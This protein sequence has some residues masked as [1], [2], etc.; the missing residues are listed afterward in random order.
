MG[1]KVCS[2]CKEPLE[3][4]SE[5]YNKCASSKDGLQPM[6]RICQGILSTVYGRKNS[7][8]RKRFRKDNPH[9]KR[10]DHLKRRYNTDI[11]S[12]SNIMNEQRGICPICE[13]SLVYPDSRIN[14]S[15][16]HN[17]N[18]GKVRGLLCGDCNRALGIMKEDKKAILAMVSYLEKYEDT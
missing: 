8:K 4:A 6:C 3:D 17:H 9:I 11:E 5:F 15:I 10:F 18:T 2:K 14:Y 12:I 13:K 7:E 16:D 1:I